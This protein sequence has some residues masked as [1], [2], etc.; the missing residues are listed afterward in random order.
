MLV[1]ENLLI[2][3]TNSAKSLKTHMDSRLFF[4]VLLLTAKNID[5]QIT[6]TQSELV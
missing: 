4:Y 5:N 2:F 6:V 1:V 3:K